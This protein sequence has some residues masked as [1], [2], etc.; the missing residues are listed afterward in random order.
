VLLVGDDVMFVDFE[1]EP[2]RPVYERLLKRS[3]LHDVATMIRSLQYAAHGT[4]RKRPTD[5]IS[6][7][8]TGWL[9][10]W[11]QRLS[12][13]FLASYLEAMEGTSLLPRGHATDPCC[14]T[15]CC[16]NGRTTRSG[17]S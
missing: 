8:A 4:R 7:A 11:Q 2:G 10:A 13:V 6:P 16:S 12:S 5:R 17:S 1:G 15:R 9:R 14:C 3:P